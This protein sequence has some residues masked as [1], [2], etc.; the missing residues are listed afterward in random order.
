LFKTN[1]ILK[2][3]LKTFITSLPSVINIGSLLL[4]IILIYAILG[5]NFFG[6]VK[7]SGELNVKS[8]FQTLETSYI[9]MIRITSGENWPLLMEALS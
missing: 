7:F 1:R 9:T 5:V 4:L 8:N 3:T 6:D 2:T